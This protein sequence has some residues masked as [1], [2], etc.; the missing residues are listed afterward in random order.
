M[1]GNAKV[2]VKLLKKKGEK[3]LKAPLCID[4]VAFYDF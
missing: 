2:A 4:I 1:I 3:P